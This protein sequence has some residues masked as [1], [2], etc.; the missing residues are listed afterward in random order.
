MY[1]ASCTIEI[2]KLLQVIPIPIF[3]K[4]HLCLRSKRVLKSLLHFT[5]QILKFEG[6]LRM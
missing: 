1:L 6:M 5:R 4:L 3:K 2:I